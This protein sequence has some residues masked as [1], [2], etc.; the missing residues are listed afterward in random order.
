M[1]NNVKSSKKE[2]TVTKCVLKVHQKYPK[3][4][5]IYLADLSN[6]TKKLLC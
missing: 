4:L 6:Q 1:N 5:T 2:V 3:Y